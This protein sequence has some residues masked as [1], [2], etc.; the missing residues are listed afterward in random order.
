MRGRPRS[1]L[2]KLRERMRRT[3]IRKKRLRNCRIGRMGLRLSL[4]LLP[5]DQPHT[6]RLLRKRRRCRWRV[7]R[8]EREGGP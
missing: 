1:R 6:P 3:L 2:Q 4:T 8:N 5:R 7:T